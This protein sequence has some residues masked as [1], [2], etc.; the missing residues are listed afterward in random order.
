[1]TDARSAKKGFKSPE[2]EKPRSTIYNV[3]LQPNLFLLSSSPISFYDPIT[4]SRRSRVLEQ[5]ACDLPRK[6]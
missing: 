1:M 4:A 2:E 6:C 5:G 3:S